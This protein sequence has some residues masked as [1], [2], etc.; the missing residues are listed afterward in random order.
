VRV[1]VRPRVG[2]LS[3]GDELVE[4]GGALGPGQIH[5][6]NGHALASLVR[7]A[8]TAA[9]LD[10]LAAEEAG[11]AA[12]AVPAARPEVRAA[13]FLRALAR[14]KPSVSAADER[15]YL[16]MQARLRTSRAH[17]DPEGEAP[18]AEAEGAAAAA[19]VGPAR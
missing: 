3:T 9:L 10:H 16:A 17:M 5:S 11:A 18:A 14:V 13:H 6:S 19:P 1:A 12:A 15:R 8:A 7:E 2:I 4:P